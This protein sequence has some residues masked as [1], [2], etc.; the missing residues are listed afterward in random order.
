MH[1][2]QKGRNG[3]DNVFFEDVN[4]ATLWWDSRLLTVHQAGDAFLP[5]IRIFGLLF[6]TQ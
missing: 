5:E 3:C 2:N 4:I 6:E 1:P